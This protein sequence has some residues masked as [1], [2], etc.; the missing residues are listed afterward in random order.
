MEG[1]RGCGAFTGAGAQASRGQRLDVR[2]EPGQL[3]EGDVLVLRRR[4]EGDQAGGV[5]GARG[6]KRP[7]DGSPVHDG[8]QPPQPLTGQPDSDGSRQ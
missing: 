8:R 5:G 7:R 3:V 6:G 2:A 1:G 4:L